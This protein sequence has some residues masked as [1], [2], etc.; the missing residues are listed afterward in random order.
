MERYELAQKQS[1]KLEQKIILSE[2]RIREWYEHWNGKVYIAFSGGKDSTVLL[3]VVRK[4]Y[5]ETPAVFIDTGLEYPEVVEFV[6]TFDNLTIL[7]PEMNFKQVIEKYGY[8]VISKETS[9]KIREVRTRPK[10]GGT[11][12]LRLTGYTMKG[13]YN[14]RAMIPEKWKKLLDAPFKISEECCDIMKKNP[15]KIYEKET[16]RK[17]FIGTMV[18]EGELRKSVYLKQGC[19]SFDSARP[20]SKPISIWTEENIWEYIKKNNLKY[21]KVYDM[22][23]K[24]TGCMFCMFGIHMEDKDNNRFIRMKKSHPKLWKYCI[25]QCGVG[26]ALDYIGIDYE[27][28]NNKI[29]E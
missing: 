16:G 25:E 15:S 22:G 18:S 12:N 9:M 2:K 24:R 8:P 23:E 27:K 21:C 3:D 29:G 13:T 11:V 17:P 14:Y 19:N 4:I 5:P 28:L 7:K 20:T 10:H 1:L 6:K 26:K